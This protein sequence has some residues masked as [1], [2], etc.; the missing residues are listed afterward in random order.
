M[1]GGWSVTTRGR[2]AGKVR[3]QAGDAP[4]ANARIGETVNRNT[5]E[6][7]DLL[8]H[9]RIVVKPATVK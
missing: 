4:T 8:D 2:D 9:G 7:R 6:S 1:R 3:V 5:G